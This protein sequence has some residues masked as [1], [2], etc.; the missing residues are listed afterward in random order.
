MRG[1]AGLLPEPFPLLG[2]PGE[3]NKARW[4]WRC[5]AS[6]P[7]PASRIAEGG[8]A[9]V[10]LPELNL[11]KPLPD[12][13]HRDDTLTDRSATGFT[14]QYSIAVHDAF[15]SAT[16]LSSISARNTYPQKY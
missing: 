12:D 2:F 16:L 8:L 1:L 9:D 5:S 11:Y 7:P 13:A 6:S 14:R 4:Y 3:N 15:R 10:H